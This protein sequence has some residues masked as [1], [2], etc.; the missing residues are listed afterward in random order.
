[1]GLVLTLAGGLAAVIAAVTVVV[2]TAGDDPKKTSAKAAH[3]AG[4]N[5]RKNAA[6]SLKGTYAGSPATFTVTRAGTA[7]SDYTLAGD[8]VSRV[9]VGGTTYLK[10]GSRFWKAHG[11]SPAKAG[12]AGGRWTKAPYNAVELGTGNL[13]PDQLGQT[14]L[15]AENEPLAKKTVVNGIKAIRMTT[16][17]LTYSISTGEPRRVLRVEGRAANDAFSFDLTPLTASGRAMFLTTLRTDVQA[18]KDAYNPNIIF[19]ETGE[20]PRLQ[21][22][23]ASGCTAKVEL[24]P[25]AWGG[26]NAIHIVMVTTFMGDDGDPVSSC[27]DSTLATSKILARF[28]CRTSGGAWTAWYRSH[29]RRFTVRALAVFRATVNSAQDVAAMLTALTREQQTA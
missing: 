17:G 4:R 6:L 14:L 2:A 15:G 26:S 9:D 8:H 13:S 28:S 11:E 20:R 18:L 3:E 10:T 21:E 19:D 7:R 29:D 23:D 12:N 27:T 16:A 5:L 25:D 1:M 22:C 24:Q